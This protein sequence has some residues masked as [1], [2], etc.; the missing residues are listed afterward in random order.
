MPK[1]NK[2][3]TATNAGIIAYTQSLVKGYARAA[4]WVTVTAGAALGG[5]KAYKYLKAKKIAK[6]FV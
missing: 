3:S 2:I 5:Y 1:S 4:I 6:E